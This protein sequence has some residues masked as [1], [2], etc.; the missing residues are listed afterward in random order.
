MKASEA[1][2]LLRGVVDP[3]LLKVIELI[4]EELSLHKQTQMTLAQMMDQLAD[5]LNVTHRMLGNSLEVV[6]SL[7]GI[8]DQI[9]EARKTHIESPTALEDKLK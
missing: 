5:N 6:K 1:R 9:S 8:K 7:K 2:A 4:C 3:R